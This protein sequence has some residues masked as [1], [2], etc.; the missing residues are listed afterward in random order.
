MEPSSSDAPLPPDGER[1]SILLVDDRPENLMALRASLEELD[2]E[3]V[4]AGSG[5]EALRELLRRD[6][7]LILLDV[8]MPEMDGL[9]TASLIRQRESS[10]HTPIIFTTAGT[11]SELNL[12]RGYELGAIDYLFTPIEP[13]VLR[14]K[15]RA[16]IELERR[17]RDLRRREEWLRQAAE[18]RATLLES[19]LQALLELLEVGYFRCTLDGLLLEGNAAF[20][21]LTGLEAGPDVL[22]RVREVRAGRL[23]W[24]ELWRLDGAD[25][26]LPADA[27]IALAKG[28]RAWVSIRSTRVDSGGESWIKGLVTDIARTK[29]AEQDLQRANQVLQRTNE[30]MNQFVYAA[31]HD[32][33]EPLRMIVA[34]G[35]LLQRR[36]APQLDAQSAG[37]LGHVVDGGARMQA[38][39]K[40]LLGYMQASAEDEPEGE[41]V[42][43]EEVLDEVLLNLQGALRESGARVAHGPLP[44]VRAR[45]VHVLQIL[46]NLIS[47]GIKYRAAAPPRIEVGAGREGELAVL[48]VRDEGQGFKQEYAQHIFGVFKRLHGR[49]YPGTGIGLALCARLVAIHGGRIWAESEPG[50]GA[51]FRFSLPADAS[52]AAAPPA[53]PPEDRALSGE[54]AAS[55]P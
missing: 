37:F 43:C 42:D 17:H 54:P 16:F 33:Q 22:A 55:P 2:Q 49:D 41:P 34:Y 44:R 1:C 30:D 45:R 52:A 21:R 25:G 23:G 19:R 26:G 51:T 35:Q 5:R 39:L 15:V 46:Q 50:R 36:L 13:A 3:L 18:R 4:T 12:A 7:A 14:A 38:L 29:R 28:Q 10:L 53:G 6:F 47:N 8:N 32:L 40:D 24:L 11:A 27:E 31:S 9:E 20:A 48:W